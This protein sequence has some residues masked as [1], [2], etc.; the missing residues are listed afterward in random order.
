MPD[1]FRREN[2][3]VQFNHCHCCTF[4]RT[5]IV[6]NV[7][8][9]ITIVWDKERN[10]SPSAAIVIIIVEPLVSRLRHPL[11]NHPPFRRI[12]RVVIVIIIDEPPP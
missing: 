7:E 2:S 5:L 11:T 1:D 4:R 9:G 10:L 8:L 3:R 6:L 12:C